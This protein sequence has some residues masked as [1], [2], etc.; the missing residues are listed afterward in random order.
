M[1]LIRY[2]LNLPQWIDG[3][4]ITSI[5]GNWTAT[6]LKVI[7]LNNIT[8]E[9][10]EHGEVVEGSVSGDTATVVYDCYNIP[11]GTRYLLVKEPSGPFRLTLGETIVGLTSG[12]SASSQGPP[13]NDYGSLATFSSETNTVIQGASL[14]GGELWLVA[15]PDEDT[16]SPILFGSHR[17]SGFYQTANAAT[18]GDMAGMYIGSLDHLPGTAVY[19]TPFQGCSRAPGAQAYYCSLRGL[20]VSG[21]GAIDGWTNGIELMLPNSG[22][23][24]E[25]HNRFVALLAGQ[26]IDIANTRAQ[27]VLAPGTSSGVERAIAVRMDESTSPFGAQ[28]CWLQPSTGNAYYEGA[29]A[30]FV[31]VNGTT[32]IRDGYL[33]WDVMDAAG[34]NTLSEVLRFGYDS[35]AS[36]G[37]EGFLTLNGVLCVDYSKTILPSASGSPTLGDSTNPWP[38]VSLVNGY[39]RGDT[40]TLQ[41]ISSAAAL[42]GIIG[43]D[44]PGTSFAVYSAYDLTLSAVGDLILQGTTVTAAGLAL[45]DDA[46]A[47]AQ[48]TTLGLGSLATASSVNDGNWSGTDLAVVNGGTGASDAATA[49]TNLGLAIGTDVQA[50]NAELAALAGLTSAADALPYFTGSGTAATTTLTAAARTVLDDTTV[51]A[52]V[53]TLG[54]ASSTGSGG[55]VR[56]TSPTLVTPV[57]GTPASGV[58]T[59]CTGQYISGGSHFNAVQT[60]TTKKFYPIRGGWQSSNNIFSTT[61]RQAAAFVGVIANWYFWIQQTPAGTLTIQVD[62]WTQGTNISF[63]TTSAG[64]TTDTSS[65]TIVTAS[66][67]LTWS[68]VDSGS[69]GLS[70]V[71]LAWI[72][73]TT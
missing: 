34:S 52:M 41:F 7:H 20:A 51:A 27:I 68:V 9:P 28:L 11:A 10:F 50:Y 46:D 53:N 43:I 55:L 35:T 60:N 8:G 26:W 63:T 25:V 36:A 32:S 59:N 38:G 30:T 44:E 67:L 39:V 6:G 71:N 56:A 61:V 47:S 45:L 49:R 18:G 17:R 31:P 40:G 42:R 3:T 24:T 62:N 5:P 66:D 12:A 13:L 14:A 33:R 69:T 37:E 70:N 54:G 21:S 19:G 2:Q 1:E 72:G 48:R 57:L 4:D 58:L 22:G 16:A 15:N 23:T 64:L 65:L 73:R 29:V